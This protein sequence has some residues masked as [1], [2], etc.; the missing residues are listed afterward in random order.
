[1]AAG[2][3]YL[4]ASSASATRYISASV[5][6]IL[7]AFTHHKM[8]RQLSWVYPFVESI[9]SMLGEKPLR[10]KVLSMN[11]S[12]VSS[13]LPVHLCSHHSRVRLKS[14]LVFAARCFAADSKGIHGYL[15]FM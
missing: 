10:R 7:N 4:L 15:P 1:M 3:A 2:S 14:L 9:R 12:F 13:Q 11:G 8:K 5:S 6:V